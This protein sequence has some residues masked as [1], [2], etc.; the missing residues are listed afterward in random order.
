MNIQNVDND[1]NQV[2]KIQKNIITELVCNVIYVFLQ[3]VLN[4]FNSVKQGW[5]GGSRKNMLSSLYKLNPVQ[6]EVGASTQL[7]LENVILVGAR[8]NMMVGALHKKEFAN[9]GCSL[10]RVGAQIK[11]NVYL[12]LSCVCD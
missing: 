1:G 6:V 10:I 3:F 8:K 4:T 2:A 7:Y 11:M 12:S 5:K 9:R